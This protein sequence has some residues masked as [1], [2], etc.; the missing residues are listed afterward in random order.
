MFLSRLRPLVCLTRQ[1]VT[2]LIKIYGFTEKILNVNLKLDA[3]F[4]LLG[5]YC[6]NFIYCNGVKNCC[7]NS[8]IVKYLD[9]ETHFANQNTQNKKSVFKEIILSTCMRISEG[10]SRYIGIF[11]V[12]TMR[13][14]MHNHNFWKIKRWCLQIVHVSQTQIQNYIHSRIPFNSDP[15][16]LKKCIF[17]KMT[18]RENA[19]RNNSS[20]CE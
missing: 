16:L 14:P 17:L 2:F 12:V 15:V 20:G 5:Y 6:V 19:Y 10:L 11:S 1:L 7:E 4:H 8:K 9:I 18:R 3:E 13:T